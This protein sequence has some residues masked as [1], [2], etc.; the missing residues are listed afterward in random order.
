MRNSD[1][2]SKISTATKQ[3]QVN[4]DLTP[5]AEATTQTKPVSRRHSL[6]SYT[7]PKRVNKEQQ[8]GPGTNDDEAKEANASASSM[9]I[10]DESVDDLV[11][12]HGTEEGGQNRQ[13]LHGLKVL[14]DVRDQDGEDAS[15]VWMEKLRSVGAKV[16]SKPPQPSRRRK[17]SAAAKQ[18]CSSD[19]AVA[20]A[21][22]C[23]VFKH[24]KPA[25]LHYYRSQVDAGRQPVI[26]G[27]N[28][29]LHCLRVGEKVEE[30]DYLVEVGKHPLFAKVSYSTICKHDDGRSTDRLCLAS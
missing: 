3:V 22:D 17:S 14:V 20:P 1:G 26:V 30:C 10:G 29:V 6:Y 5:R 21:L 2:D 19:E 13:F 28:W 12:S 4:S 27:V 15:A 8:C 7:P 18:E 25:T 24:G 23:I 11:R 9:V 16:Y